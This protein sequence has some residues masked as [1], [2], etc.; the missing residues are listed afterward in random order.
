MTPISSMDSITFSWLSINHNTVQQSRALRPNMDTRL[1]TNTT[2]HNLWA[3]LGEQCS[4]SRP[5]PTHL[6]PPLRRRTP[7]P[8]VA[9]ERHRSAPWFSRWFKSSYLNT[10]SRAS[11][12]HQW[13]QCSSHS[14]T[15]PG[16]SSILSQ[17][18]IQ[19]LY[20]RFKVFFFSSSCLSPSR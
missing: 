1:R 16:Y 17:F 10:S 5:A 9:E 13:T 4:F 11:W 3:S 18:L 15:I 20:C 7:L 2:T 8:G 14:D 19:P 12:F 6:C